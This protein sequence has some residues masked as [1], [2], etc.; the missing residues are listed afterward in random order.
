MNGRDTRLDDYQEES[1]NEDETKGKHVIT[2]KN[3]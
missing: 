1:V 3:Y 2:G